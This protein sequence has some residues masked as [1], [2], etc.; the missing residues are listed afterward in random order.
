MNKGAAAAAS[1]ARNA[2]KAVGGSPS[3]GAS[4]D[5]KGRRDNLSLDD[6]IRAAVDAQMGQI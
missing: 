6:E 2:A 4:P 5:S 3:P 1:K